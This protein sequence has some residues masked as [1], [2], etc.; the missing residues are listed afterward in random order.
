MS[1]NGVRV[2]MSIVRKGIPQIERV[3]CN[4]SA[5]TVGS[6]L[7]EGVRHMKALI[8]EADEEARVRRAKFKK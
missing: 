8:A 2:G 4:Y 1:S 6:S 5:Y 7:S 3:A